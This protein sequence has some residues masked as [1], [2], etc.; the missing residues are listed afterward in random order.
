MSKKKFKFDLD[1]RLLVSKIGSFEYCAVQYFRSSAS[2]GL[3]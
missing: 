2:Y 3:I 1:S